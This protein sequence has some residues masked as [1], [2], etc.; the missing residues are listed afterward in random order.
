MR[1]D[2]FLELRLGFLA[3]NLMIL[4][5]ARSVIRSRLYHFIG[6]GKRTWR[7]SL[8]WHLK[9]ECSKAFITDIYESFKSVYLPTSAME[10]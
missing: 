4:P 3:L 8:R 2:I 6:I 9:A 1:R 5:T 7:I 10:T